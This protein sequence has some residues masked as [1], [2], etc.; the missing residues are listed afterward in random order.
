MRIDIL[1]T[2]LDFFLG[3]LQGKISAGPIV[4]IV[5]LFPI[6]ELRGGILAGYALGL[7]L[8]P[9]FTIAYIGNL[10]PIPFILLLIRQIFKILKNTP[11][12]KLVLYFERKALEKSDNIQ[13]F[14]YWGLF[15]FV[16]IPL[17]GTGAWTGALAATLLGLDIK[18]SFVTIAAGVFT[19]G[20]IMSILSFGLLSAVG[21]G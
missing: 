17:P 3:V 7:E 12:K 16:A 1:Q 21:I 9:S 13:K 5:S 2:L 6:I 19:A 18:K 14:G 15:I 4:F 11:M 10:I 20:V 8:L